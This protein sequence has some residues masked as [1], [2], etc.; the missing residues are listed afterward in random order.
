MAELEACQ[1]KAE[2]AMR[3]LAR[4]LNRVVESTTVSDA[5][6]RKAEGKQG[7]PLL[8]AVGG[9]PYYFLRALAR[10]GQATVSMMAADLGVTLAAV[11]VLANKLAQAGWV[12]RERNEQDRRVV[13]LSLTSLGREVLE[14]T[15][16]VRKEVFSHFFR[17]LDSEEI[18]VLDRIM[19]K[20]LARLQE[21]EREERENAAG[22]A[23]PEEDR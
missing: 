15:Q 4:R 16:V 17:V 12:V 23:F 2:E 11:T 18:A 10:R 6:S 20:V 5:A 21:E 1:Q 7:L 9:G 22:G 3:L 14:Y 8:A 13:W 19:A